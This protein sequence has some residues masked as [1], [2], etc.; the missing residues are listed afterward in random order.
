[1]TKHSSFSTSLT[2]RCVLQP[3]KNPI[4]I[5][6]QTK[7]AKSLTSSKVVLILTFLS[8]FT[9]Q[10]SLF[11]KGWDSARVFQF[12]AQFDPGRGQHNNNYTVGH[13]KRKIPSKIRTVCKKVQKTRN[14]SVLSKNSII[15]LQNKTVECCTAQRSVVENHEKLRDFDTVH[16]AN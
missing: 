15:C 4:S 5:K 16:P 13:E 7:S 6:F 9:P 10:C 3:P 1:M 11:L 8:V 14:G 12:L 2:P